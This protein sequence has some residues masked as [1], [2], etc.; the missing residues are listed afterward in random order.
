M[1]VC[2]WNCRAE[3]QTVKGRILK[4][5]PPKYKMISDS[6]FIY[7]CVCVCVCVCVELS[8]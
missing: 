7:V 3:T 2:V 1:C 4:R 6:E 5:E 8:C